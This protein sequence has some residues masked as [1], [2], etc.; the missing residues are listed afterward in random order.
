MT[1]PYAWR[2][3][4]TWWAATFQTP[5]FKSSSCSSTPTTST[6]AVR[7]SSLQ[8]PLK[9]WCSPSPSPLSASSPSWCIWSFAEARAAE[10][11]P[12][13]SALLIRKDVKHNRSVAQV[14]CCCVKHFP[15]LPFITATDSFC[16]QLLWRELYTFSG[17]NL[18]IPKFI[19]TFI[20]ILILLKW[21]K[22][23]MFSQKCF[24]CKLQI[25]KNSKNVIIFN[26]LTRE[27]SSVTLQ[28]NIFNI[29]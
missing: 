22:I 26:P 21:I 25:Q 1:W 8:T 13:Q 12:K 16:L 17:T 19:T 23:K 29:L 6:T 10:A 4:L 9:A 14:V 24:I 20:N 11:K 15:Q 27:S 3:W 5:T 7:S 2:W 28:H 18:Y